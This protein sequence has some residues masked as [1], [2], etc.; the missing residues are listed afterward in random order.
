MIRGLSALGPHLT[1][2]ANPFTNLGLMDRQ[3]SAAEHC[4]PIDAHVVMGG[5]LSFLVI[6]PRTSRWLPYWDGSIFALLILRLI[7]ACVVSCG[8]IDRIN[9]P[10]QTN[11][12]RSA[13][14]SISQ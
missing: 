2:V 9:E 3:G 6:D 10:K 5:A 13:I 7:A 11:P 12:T 4:A 14:K 1:V 8:P